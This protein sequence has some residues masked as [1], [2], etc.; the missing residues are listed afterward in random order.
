MRLAHDRIVLSADESGRT[1]ALVDRQRNVE[2][3]LD[4]SRQTFRRRD[5]AGEPLI[6]CGLVG[7]EEP[8]GSQ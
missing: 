8:A 2:W 1:I 4:P 6:A 7:M 5:A 3:K